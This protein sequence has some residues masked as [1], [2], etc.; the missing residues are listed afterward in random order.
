M[1]WFFQPPSEEKEA[2]GGMPWHSCWYGQC[3]SYF[4][5]AVTKQHDQGKL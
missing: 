1:T 3:P 2:E 4:S 5:I